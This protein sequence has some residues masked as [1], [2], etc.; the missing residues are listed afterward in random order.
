[1][2]MRTKMMLSLAM[3]AMIVSCAKVPITGRRQLNLVSEGEMMSMANSQYQQFLGE[4]QALPATNTEVVR[5][6]N[7][8]NKLA[9][10][11]TTYLND[12]GAAKR[13]E[14]FEWAFNVVDDPTVNAW[15]M[16]G[17]KVAAASFSIAAIASP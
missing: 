5:V 17:G 6:R 2:N 15:C 3:L 12:N 10:A 11:A 14:G 4:N 9:Q 8:G 16:P 7:I 13:V 1:M